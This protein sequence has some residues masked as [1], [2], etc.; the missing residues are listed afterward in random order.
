MEGNHDL[1][2]KRISNLQIFMEEYI[3]DNL[4]RH[5]PVYVL[6]DVNDIAEG[7]L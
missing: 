2:D 3:P 4:P 7:H 5:R 6:F 1:R